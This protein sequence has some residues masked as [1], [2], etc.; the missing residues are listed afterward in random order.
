MTKQITLSFGCLSMI[1]MTLAGCSSTSIN[2]VDAGTVQ[3]DVVET[4]PIAVSNVKVRHNGENIS[5]FGRVHR[6]GQPTLAIPG[7]VDIS[8]IAPNGDVIVERQVNY[9]TRRATRHSRNGYFAERF[10][11]DI[12][13]DTTIRVV[14]H[15]GDHNASK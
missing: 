5:V 1:L 12:P 7:H 14:H 6:W 2:M 13:D 11:L 10:N 15:H 9:M 8:F 4:H 3:L